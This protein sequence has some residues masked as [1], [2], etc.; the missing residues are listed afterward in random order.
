MLKK[1]KFFFVFITILFFILLF[2]IVFFVKP[3][4][5]WD[6]SL[7][8][9]SG[10]EMFEKRYFLFPVW[11]GKIWFDK[12]P[13]IPFLYAL[14]IKTFPFILPEI[15]TR[16][17]TLLIGTATLTL[18]YFFYYSSV[19]HV[20]MSFVYIRTYFLN[21]SKDQNSSGWCIRVSSPGKTAP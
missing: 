14:I 2:K 1:H 18:L 21:D 9:K 4:Y 10:L 11:Q 16:I 8:I 7:Y 17:F 13:L 3:F 20:Y 12:P 5:D 6:E 19:S 15:S